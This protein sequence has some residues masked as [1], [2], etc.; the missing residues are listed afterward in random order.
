MASASAAGQVAVLAGPGAE[1][2]VL[3]DRRAVHGEQVAQGDGDVDAGAGA[4]PVRDHLGADEE[5]AGLLEGVVVALPAV[6]RSSGPR[7]LP[8]ASRTAVSAAA[9]SGV[10]SP[11]IRPA[12]SRVVSR[13]RDRSPKPVPVG[14][15]VGVGLPGAPGLVGG[16]GEEL[17]VVEAGPG[18]GGLDE[19]LVGLG[20]E[21]VVVDPAG[22]PRD[23]P[24]PRDR[25]RAGGGGGVQAAGGG[26][27]AASGGR[28]PWRPWARG[29]SWRRARRSWWRTRRRRGRHRRRTAAAARWP[30]RRAA[31]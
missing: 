29:G 25:Q 9:H 23:L 14:V 21:V 16:L 2:G 31:R 4:G 28:R 7:L 3:D 15:F 12:P 10:R 22:P 6:R 26:P 30:R 1:P 20:L 18:G 27:G 11:R 8:R 17:Q 5:L 13:S 19:D 24:R